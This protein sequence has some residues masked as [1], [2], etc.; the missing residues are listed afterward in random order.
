MFHYQLFYF[1]RIQCK[2]QL[3]TVIHKEFV[4]FLE[5]SQRPLLAFNQLLLINQLIT[6]KVKVNEVN[7]AEPRGGKFSTIKC[8]DLIKSFSCL[9]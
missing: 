8:I 4:V 2:N 1:I 6:W 7:P 9:Y 5:Y 3:I